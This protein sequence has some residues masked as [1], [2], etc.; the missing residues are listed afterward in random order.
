MRICSGCGKQL[1]DNAVTCSYCGYGY[2]ENRG[3]P[4][5]DQQKVEEVTQ[6][7]QDASIKVSRVIGIITGIPFVLIGFLI[8]FGEITNF[9]NSYKYTEEVN[10]VY[11]D[12]VNCEVFDTDEYCDIVYKYEV[13]GKEY[14][15][16]ELSVSESSFAGEKELLYDID[17][18]SESISK[19]DSECNIIFLIMGVIFFF[20]GLCAILGKGTAR[21]NV[22]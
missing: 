22:H 10:G 12:S 5:I 9:I 18:P 8:A 15:Y 3:I 13:N 6:K 21:V 17:N 19:S 16:T 2:K 20:A 4:Q 7:I 1:N 14:T 11:K